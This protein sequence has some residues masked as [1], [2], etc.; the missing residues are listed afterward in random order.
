MLG[1]EGKDWSELEPVVRS[2]REG[3]GG[4][5]GSGA[6]WLAFEPLEDGFDGNSGAGLPAWASRTQPVRKETMLVMTNQI[7]RPSLIGFFMEIVLLQ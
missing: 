1:S 7:R 4:S 5:V 6:N 3:I 2:F